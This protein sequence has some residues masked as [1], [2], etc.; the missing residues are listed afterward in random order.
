MEERPKKKRLHE[1][2]LRVLQCY[3]L[4][5]SNVR[6]L[7]LACGRGKKEGGGGGEGI[8]RTRAVHTIRVV[9]SYGE[10]NRK[11]T[12]LLNFERHFRPSDHL[13]KL[14]LVV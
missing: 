13:S 9:T 5:R 11:E 14:C 10:K 12:C 6:C 7:L 8:N 2:V 3:V 1:R 4:V